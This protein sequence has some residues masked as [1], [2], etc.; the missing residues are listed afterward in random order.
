MIGS[1]GNFIHKD[2]F[3]L[4]ADNFW[5]NNWFKSIPDE[6]SVDLKVFIS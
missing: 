1:E 2:D 6:L 3:K 5:V 4:K